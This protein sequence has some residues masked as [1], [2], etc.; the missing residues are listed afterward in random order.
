MS[1]QK[2]TKVNGNSRSQM[3][4]LSHD[5]IYVTTLGEPHEKSSVLIQSWGNAL[6]FTENW[7]TKRQVAVFQTRAATIG[8]ARSLTGLD[9]SGVELFNIMEELGQLSNKCQTVSKYTNA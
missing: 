3:I 5:Y 4:T 8:K 2:L 6:K 9:I 1:Q 7:T